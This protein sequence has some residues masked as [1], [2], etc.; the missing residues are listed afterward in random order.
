MPAL[1]A[2]FSGPSIDPVSLAGQ[3]SAQHILPGTTIVFQRDLFSSEKRLPIPSNVRLTNA[4]F[5][6]SAVAYGSGTDFIDLAFIND[7]T[8][9][10][11][12][13][14]KKLPQLIAPDRPNFSVQKL[15]IKARRHINDSKGRLLIRKGT[16]YTYFNTPMEYIVG[17][18]P[19]LAQLTSTDEYII[20]TEGDDKLLE[21]VAD[22]ASHAKLTVSFGGV[23]FGT[24]NVYS[25]SKGYLHYDSAVDPL[26]QSLNPEA[27]LTAINMGNNILPAGMSLTIDSPINS[28]IY[29]LINGSLKRLSP[30]EISWNEQQEVWTIPTFASGKNLIISTQPLYTAPEYVGDQNNVYSPNDPLYWQNKYSDTIVKNPMTG[31]NPNLQGIADSTAPEYVGDQN[32]VYSPNDPLY[33]QNKYSDTIVKNPMTGGNP[34][35]QGIADSTAPAGSGSA[36]YYALYSSVTI[37]LGVV[38]ILAYIR[39]KKSKG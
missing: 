31:G 20:L 21:F 17:H 14:L 15:I 1:A 27:K 28:Y 32:N 16:E 8:Q 11:H 18:N 29:E 37:Y 12:I 19:E 34:N 3:N 6:I 33:W 26:I 13:R 23:A 10:V 9:N 24:M 25:G 7:S 36:I 30:P 35:L 4:N 39:L 2:S 5:E 22:S 38:L